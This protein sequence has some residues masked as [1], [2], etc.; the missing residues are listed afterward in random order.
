LPRATSS[1]CMRSTRH[2]RMLDTRS[3]DEATPDATEAAGRTARAGPHP[4]IHRF[5]RDSPLEERG[6]E[7]LV[8]RTDG[9]AFPKTFLPPRA[10][11][12]E[13]G[14]VPAAESG[15]WGR[16][17]LSS[18]AALL[19]T[20]QGTRRRIPSSAADVWRCSASYVAGALAVVPPAK[21]LSV[22][23]MKVTNN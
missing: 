4:G 14:S 5:A 13:G 12:S 20:R 7:R 9:V 23:P 21:S 17:P 22:P 18:T 2:Q 16:I 8:P 3:A 6:F 19:R 11:P 10:A 1:R 15:R